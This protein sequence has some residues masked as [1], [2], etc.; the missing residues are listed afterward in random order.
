MAFGSAAIPVPP[1]ATPTRRTPIMSPPSTCASPIATG[2]GD[3]GYGGEWPMPQI[4]PWSDET[5]RRLQFR[6]LHEDFMHREG[7]AGWRWPD[8]QVTYNEADQFERW[9]IERWLAHVR[10]PEYRQTT[11]Y[12]YLRAEWDRGR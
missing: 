10:S 5:L 7:F 9:L 8:P 3:G 2:C 12:L 4:D 11:D 1:S 6:T